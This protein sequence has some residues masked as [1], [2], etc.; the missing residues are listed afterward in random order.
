MSK[1][2]SFATSSSFDFELESVS[3]K[4]SS[5][6]SPSSAEE[7]SATEGEA[8]GF[9]SEKP[10]SIKSSSE[11]SP[12]SPLESELE[13]LESLKKSSAEISVFSGISGKLSSFCVSAFG[14][15]ILSISGIFSVSKDSISGSSSSFNFGSVK[16]SSEISLEISFVILERSSSESVELSSGILSA[17]K[18]SEITGSSIETSSELIG[19]FSASSSVVSC[20]S[21]GGRFTQTP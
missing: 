16:E 9:G 21:C 4:S 3:K 1:G 14:S 17:D 7:K 2:S 5:E 8:P 19:A 11:I 18:S 13:E 6:I 12:S 15:E 10:P 20:A